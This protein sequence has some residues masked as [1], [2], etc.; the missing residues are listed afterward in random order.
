MVVVAA[1]TAATAKLIKPIINDIFLGKQAALLWPVTGAVFGVFLLK[2][3][4]TYLESATMAFVG[5]RIIADIQNDLFKRI[6]QADLKFFQQMQTGDLV[7]RFMSDVSRLNNAVTG[8]L[9]SLGKDA[10]TLIF[11]IYVMF[12]EDWQLACVVFFVFPV[13]IMPVIT[14]GRK[15]RKASTRVQ[16]Q[17]ADLTVM[18]TQAFQGI[19]LIKSYCM[20]AYE[21][22]RMQEVIE[23]VFKRSLKGARTKSMTHPIMEFLGGVAIATVILYGGS[24]VIQ[25]AQ[26][27]GA[28]FA[29]ITALIMSYEPL[30]RIAN[31]NANLQE[32]LAAADRVFSLLQ[33]ENAIQDQHEAAPLLITK[34][35]VSFQDVSFHYQA[36]EPILKTITLTLKAGQK[37]ALV[38]PSGGGKSTLMNLIPRF[39]DPTEGCILIDGQDIKRGTLTSLRQNIALVSQEI[40]LFDDTIAANIGFGKPGATLEEIKAAAEAA[41]ADR[42]IEALPEGYDTLVG[43]QG[44]RL[45]G[46]QRQR[47]SIARAFLKNAPILLMDE[48][49]SALDSESEQKVQQALTQLMKGRTTLIIAHRLATVRDADVIY[50]LE[51]GQITAQGSHEQLLQYST[52]YQDLCR[53]QFQDKA[54]NAEKQE[55]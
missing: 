4:F 27:P 37:A 6:I 53:M 42:F 29:F 24:Q 26:T 1:T 30:K 44:L 22:H 39:F 41:A 40:I 8:T 25:G 9:T 52:L 19:R 23:T 34:G 36:Q 46:G 16:E 45:S 47:L 38:G 17:T 12:S 54:L 48:P 51:A 33:Y 15:M 7:S 32:Q 55:A 21:N 2:G 13:A 10:L 31:L 14:I 18:L 35:E 28:F 50:L 20:E 11:F 49:T 3:L 43:E 5:H